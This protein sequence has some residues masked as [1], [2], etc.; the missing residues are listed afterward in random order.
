MKKLVIIG[1]GHA[2][3]EVLRQLGANPLPGVEITLISPD[4]H[5]P[6]SG[7]LPGLVAGHYTF[8]ECHIDLA[9]LAQF[10][11]A[12]FLQISVAAIDPARRVITLEDAAQFTYDIASI[13]VGSTPPA[14]QIA[15]AREHA[16][17]VKPVKHLLTAWDTLIARVR[18][19]EVR[20]LAMVGG[21]AAGVEMLLAMQHRL[22]Q[23]R[24]PAL[25]YVLVTDT[26]QLL[27]QHA[28]GV[29]ATLTRSLA[30]KRVEV[31]A[32]TRITRIDPQTLVSENGQRIAAD[33]IFLATGAAAPPWLMASGL[34][35]NP[36][37]FL[38]INR[39]LQSTSHPEVFAAGD[40][41]TI[42]G[43]VYPKSGVYAVRQGPPL[44]QNLRRVLR[45][46]SL[47]DYTPQPRTLALISTGEQHAIASW[48]PLS[49]HG[50]WVW[51][52][53][54]SIDRKFM[55]KYR[56]PWQPPALA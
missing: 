2:H 36:R 52:W 3:V 18:A 1:G 27:V 16:M 49:C 23:L 32:A 12:R 25:R 17:A 44:A 50:N 39:H 34:A 55:A 26:P 4:R 43:Q 31:H 10:A 53:K 40:C 42:E 24:L 22:T 8:D 54:D 33:A 29:R 48:G 7:M 6:Y 38:N 21:G 37:Q 20:S 30:R 56:P 45:G 47:I 19:G 11:G 13:D 35:L 14:Q 28:R 15:G 41:A 5:T 51:R 9:P 46:E